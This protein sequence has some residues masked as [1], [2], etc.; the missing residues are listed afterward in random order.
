MGVARVVGVGVGV[1]VGVCAGVVGASERGGGLEPEGEAGK[2]GGGGAGAKK[3]GEEAVGVWWCG[4][5][6]TEPE[7]VRLKLWEDKSG[8]AKVAD[9][10]CF[11][12]EQPGLEPVGATC[13]EL[14][15]RPKA[16]KPSWRTLDRSRCRV[17]AGVEAEDGGVVVAA[18]S[19]VGGGDGP[20][21]VCLCLVHSHTAFHSPKQHDKN[22]YKPKY[23]HHPHPNSTFSTF[24]TMRPIQP[25]KPDRLA[26][27]FSHHL[28]NINRRHLDVPHV[29]CFVNRPRRAR[30]GYRRASR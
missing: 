28:H 21:D 7:A 12:I 26:H 15:R 25:Y 6:K 29:L 1:G 18:V 10:V 9:L 14:T 17:V 24:S 8:S 20:G 16:A 11:G 23:A 2:S 27:H 13:G 22:K 4:T 3:S 30:P 5:A 19:R